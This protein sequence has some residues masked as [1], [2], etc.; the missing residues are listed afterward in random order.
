M[1]KADL[2]LLL[3]DNQVHNF[4]PVAEAFKVSSRRS[5]HAR[6][7]RHSTGEELVR[8]NGVDMLASYCS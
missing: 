8:E 1:T 3:A 6:K 2:T 4:D 7:V 5:R